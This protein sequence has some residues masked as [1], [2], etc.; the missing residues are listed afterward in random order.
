MSNNVRYISFLIPFSFFQSCSAMD[1]NLSEKV[2]S[3][4]FSRYKFVDGVQKVYLVQHCS[5]ITELKNSYSFN[6]HCS[7]LNKKV[8]LFVKSTYTKPDLKTFVRN[9]MKHYSDGHV[10]KAPR[11]NISPT[12]W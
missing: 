11:S 6:L 9:L 12:L 7:K 8:A 1:Q 10:I 2:K 3:F 4:I 5:Q